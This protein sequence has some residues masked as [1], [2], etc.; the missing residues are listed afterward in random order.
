MSKTDNPITFTR[1]VVVTD[2]S[3]IDR[4][5]FDPNSEYLL[6]TFNTGSRYVYSPVSSVTF[7]AIVAA[8]SVGQRFNELIK[9]SDDIAYSKVD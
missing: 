7:A 5:E 4:M 3:T 8:D 9:E 2:S 6:V 1:T